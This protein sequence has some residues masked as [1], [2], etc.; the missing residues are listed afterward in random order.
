[1]LSRKQRKSSKKAS[2]RYQDLSEDKNKKCQCAHK[3]CRNLSEEEIKTPKIWSRT[4]QKS[5]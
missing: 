4:I 5:S 2:E 1:M 3:R